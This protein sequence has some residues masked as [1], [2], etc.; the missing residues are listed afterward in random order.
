[1]DEMDEPAQHRAQH[2]G[3]TSG[4]SYRDNIR[5]LAWT[6][7]A[8]VLICFHISQPETL[9]SILKKWQ[10]ETQFRPNAKVVLAVCEL[11]MQTI[12]PH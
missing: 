2:E 9:D 10:G 11:D 3:D 12:W 7:S 8:T 1:M 4:S 6:D 5:P